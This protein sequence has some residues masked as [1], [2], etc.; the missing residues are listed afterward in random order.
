M[1]K[2]QRPINLHV[3][4][5]TA[6]LNAAPQKKVTAFYDAAARALGFMGFESPFPIPNV[7]QKT[8]R[9]EWQRVLGKEIKNVGGTYRYDHAIEGIEE[10]PVFES[11][12]EEEDMFSKTA[13]VSKRESVRRPV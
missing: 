12:S 1:K 5:T 3:L 7:L 2:E 8:I 4:I 13:Q 11:S 10:A 9:Q 6:I